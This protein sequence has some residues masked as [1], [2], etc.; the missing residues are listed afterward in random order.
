MGFTIKDEESFNKWGEDVQNRLDSIGDLS[1]IKAALPAINAD[2]ETI[3]ADLGRRTIA[4]E[5]ETK[6]LPVSKADF[7]KS[8]IAVVLD[9]KTTA[10]A[11]ADGTMSGECDD[12]RI[13]EFHEASD[14]LKLLYEAVGGQKRVGKMSNLKFYHSHFVPALTKVLAGLDTSTSGELSQ[15]DPQEYSRTLYEKVRLVR[16]LPNLFQRISV[17]R[18]PFFAPV[19]LN[20]LV[21]KRW[22]EN[23]A[24][25]STLIE[26][27]NPTPTAIS[28]SITM[29]GASLA[30]QIAWSWELDEDSIVPMLPFLEMAVVESI[31]NGLETALINGTASGTTHIDTDTQAGSATLAE[32]LWFGL[33]YYALAAGQ[34]TASLSSAGNKINSDANWRDYVSA[35]RGAMGKYG[36]NS[37]DLVLIASPKGINQIR[38]VEAFRTIYAFGSQATNTTGGV[39]NPNGTFKPDGIETVVSEFMREDIDSTGVNT[40]ASQT[41]TSLLLVNK[42]AYVMAEVRSIRT[43]VLNEVYA[44][45]GQKG[46]IAS[47]RGDFKPLFAATGNHTAAVYGIPTV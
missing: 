28:G 39:P 31:G 34:G 16:M 5:G 9:F 35:V 10:K 40:A 24:G 21:A 19:F 13:A 18:F 17:P 30:E 46:L 7:Q 3:K 25:S 44:I 47:W 15:F 12:E 37:A 36:V 22:A 20:D 26:D 27:G 1:E 23:T 6:A 11:N 14:R 41:Y 33:R 8:G 32:K 2:I 45:N 43:Q 42:R 29:S 38:S 4:I